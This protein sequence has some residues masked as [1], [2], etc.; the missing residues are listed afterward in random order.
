VGG[1]EEDEGEDEDDSINSDKTEDGEKK[2]KTAGHAM[3]CNQCLH[4]TC[5]HAF[6]AKEVRGCRESSTCGG[7]CTRTTFHILSSI[8]RFP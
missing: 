2:E 3:G 4:P 7:T 5:E 1:V 6:K 8:S